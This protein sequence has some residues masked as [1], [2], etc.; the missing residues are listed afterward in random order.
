MCSGP[1]VSYDGKHVCC[2]SHQRGDS[3]DMWGN[4]EDP[5][6]EEATDAA[7]PRPATTTAPT[8]ATAATTTTATTTTSENAT[9]PAI[10]LGTAHITAGQAPA[11]TTVTAAAPTTASSNATTA[12]AKKKGAASA[13]NTTTAAGAAL[14]P[15]KPESRPKGK[16]VAVWP[17][18][19]QDGV[20]LKPK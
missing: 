17:P 9:A 2:N 1:F 15:V 12:T 3:A 19:P 8:T 10:A 5:A 14:V 16:Q 7:G 18:V 6:A 11:T 4:S 13:A 20:K